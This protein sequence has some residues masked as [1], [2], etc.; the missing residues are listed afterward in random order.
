MLSRIKLRHNHTSVNKAATCNL[1]LSIQKIVLATP[2]L[3]ASGTRRASDAALLSL[4]S[5][6]LATF[7]PDQLLIL[8]ATI[9]L[10]PLLTYQERRMDLNGAK[11]VILWTAP[12]RSVS[13]GLDL[14]PSPG[15]DQKHYAPPTWQRPCC[16]TT[17]HILSNTTSRIGIRP[18]KTSIARIASYI[19]A[20]CQA[21]PSFFSLQ[22]NYR[23]QHRSNCST[24]AEGQCSMVSSPA[25]AR[26]KGDRRSIISKGITHFHPSFFFVSTAFSCRICSAAQQL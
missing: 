1:L 6:S 4:L 16:A 9:I 8:T 17:S 19:A 3:H 12:G 7:M 11:T 22:S 13:L 18:I 5:C 23:R 24:L 14:C 21:L 10:N 26:E 20:S 25:N 15:L 2:C